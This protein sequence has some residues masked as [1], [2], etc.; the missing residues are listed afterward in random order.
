MNLPLGGGEPA[1]LQL[2]RAL[3]EKIV[4][5]V[6]AAGAKL[7]SKRLLAGEAGVSVVTAEHALGILTDE[8]Y[9]RPVERSGYYVIFRQ[10]ED[11]TAAGAENTRKTARVSGDIPPRTAEGKEIFPLSGAP[12]GFPFS[13]F[14]RTMRRVLSEYGERNF[15][16]RAGSLPRHGSARHAIPFV[17]HGRER[18]RLQ[19]AGIPPFC[20]GARRRGRG[21]RL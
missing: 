14:A 19:T 4:S 20:R 21:G 17:P 11:F 9:I 15:V 5:G 6:Y 18:G 12:E 1:Y 2:Y 13:V 3:R 16:L 7:P 10:G 8:G